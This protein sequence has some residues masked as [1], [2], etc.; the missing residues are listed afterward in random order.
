MKIESTGSSPAKCDGKRIGFKAPT[1]L[2]LL[3]G[4]ATSFAYWLQNTGQAWIILQLGGS[5]YDLGILAACQY[6]P[7]VLFGFRASAM[8]EAMEKRKALQAT[9]I[10]M[11]G[12]GIFLVALSYCGVLNRLSIFLVA[13]ALSLLQAFNRPLRQALLFD[14]AK[15][16]LIHRVVGINSAVNYLSRIVVPAVGGIILAN[17]HV[18]YFFLTCA[19]TYLASILFL[20]F[21]KSDSAPDSRSHAP[22]TGKLEG[23]IFLLAQDQTRMVALGLLCMTLLPF[24]FNVLVPLI[25]TLKLDLDASAYGSLLSVMAI[26][27]V[28]GALVSSRLDVDRRRLI[29]FCA[30]IIAVVEGLAIIADTLVA[31]YPLLFIAGSSVAL[32]L[33]SCN[34]LIL[35]SA[36]A[37]IRTRV[38]AV[39][40]YIAAGI[41]PLGS[42]AVSAIAGV[43]GLNTALAICALSASIV[44][45]YLL[46]KGR[47]TDTF[48]RDSW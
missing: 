44:A 12:C 20:V 18:R 17:V 32:F 39:Y 1:V 28:S 29:G 33:T 10:L 47:L 7:Y 21:L 30:A 42:V 38:A 34:T 48:S 6:G 11:S 37:E 35:Q 40:D 3:S 4:G 46:R 45:L 14:V 15:K 22:R 8:A 2:Y 16:E 26:G 23:V 13:I 5:T 36:P 25:A 43:A 19:S 27:S 9:Q 24:S 41:G 31:F